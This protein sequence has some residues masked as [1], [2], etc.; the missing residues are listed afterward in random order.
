MRIKKTPY[1]AGLAVRV[2]IVAS[3]RRYIS[4]TCNRL[5]AVAPALDVLRALSRRVVGPAVSPKRGSAVA[6]ATGVPCALVW[7]SL[8]V[9]C[10][11]RVSV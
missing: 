8:I 5:S 3:T 7:L 1:S 11:L 4:A 9:S 10:H 6:K 2:P